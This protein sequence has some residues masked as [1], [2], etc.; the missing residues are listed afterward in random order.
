MGCVVAGVADDAFVSLAV[1]ESATEVAKDVI[2]YNALPD[3]DL[4]D[5]VATVG[6]SDHL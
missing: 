6:A 4:A 1:V 3:A 2:T 5:G